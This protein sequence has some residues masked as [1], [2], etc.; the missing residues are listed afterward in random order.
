MTHSRYLS[1]SGVLLLLAFFIIALFQQQMFAQDSATLRVSLQSRIPSTEKDV[2]EGTRVIHQEI[3]H[4]N[5]KETAIIVCDMWNQHWCKGATSRVAEMAP[6]MN[7]VLTIARKQG[8]TIVHAPSDT[9][10]WYEDH[11]A[12]K[13][14]QQFRSPGIE[15]RLGRGLLDSEIE[16]A[17]PIDQSDEGC[18]CTP[19]CPLG[20]PWK[21]QIETLTIDDGDLISD[22]G[23]EIGSYFEEKGINNVILMGV[24]TN[25]CVIGRSF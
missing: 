16:S 21:H 17:W 23:V 24:H 25:M 4:W 19:T 9:L 11:P 18:D 15:T 3:Q 10:K 2:A 7:E 6:R 8:I 13:R 12:R 20:Q 1:L 5:P 14:A 22:S